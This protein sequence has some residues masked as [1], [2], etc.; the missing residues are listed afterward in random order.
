M[1]AEGYLARTVREFY[2]DLK[3]KKHNDPQLVAAIK[4]GKRCYDLALKAENEEEITA[5]PCKSKYRQPGGGRKCA[6]PDVRQALYDWF[7]DIRGVLHARLPLSLFR[8]QAKYLYEKWLAQQPE[9]VKT[10]KK[11]LLFSDRWVKGWM[12]EFGVSLRS[13]NK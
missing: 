2:S 5:P 13:P 10:N 6:A 3:D 11:Q 8:A 9:E 12:R 4:L 7:I 1:P